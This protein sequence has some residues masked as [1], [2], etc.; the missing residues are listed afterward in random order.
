MSLRR[1]KHRVNFAIFTRCALAV[2]GL[3]ILCAMFLECSRG[4]SRTEAH[5]QSSLEWAETSELTATIQKKYKIEQ[6]SL[7]V[8]ELNDTTVRM[9]VKR[10]L[11]NAKSEEEQEKLSNDVLEAWKL[12][13][14][15]HHA[16]KLPARTGLTVYLQDPDGNPLRVVGEVPTSK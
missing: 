16:R 2:A 14:L 3:V 12:T 1:T 13:Y 5:V 9:S 8:A 7:W 15:R 10:D 6:T 11:W 4:H